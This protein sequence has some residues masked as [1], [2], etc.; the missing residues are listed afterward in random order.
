MLL[1]YGTEK[2]LEEKHTYEYVDE[3]V[4]E[5]IRKKFQESTVHHKTYPLKK[6]KEGGCVI[7]SLT[8][9]NKCV[10]LFSDLMAVFTLHEFGNCL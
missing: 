3:N 10:P 2:E 1:T 8:N 7:R 9:V 5:N 4:I 6:K